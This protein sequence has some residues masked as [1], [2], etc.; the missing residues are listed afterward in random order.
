MTILKRMALVAAFILVVTGAFAAENKV[1]ETV[2]PNGLKVLIKEVHSAP[3]FTSQRL[4]HAMS[5][6][7]LLEFLTWLNI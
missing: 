6:M 3:V 2:L 7:V 5:T 1:T 4:A